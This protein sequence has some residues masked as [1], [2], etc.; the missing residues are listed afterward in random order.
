MPVKYRKISR[1]HAFQLWHQMMN[2]LTQDSYQTMGENEWKNTSEPRKPVSVRSN[3]NKGMKKNWITRSDPTGW[4]QVTSDCRD[5]STPHRMTG[6]QY[7]RTYQLQYHS[8]CSTMNPYSVSTVTKYFRQHKLKGIIY[9][10]QSNR[11]LLA[12][13]IFHNTTFKRTFQDSVIFNNDFSTKCKPFVIIWASEKC[14]NFKNAV[15]SNYYAKISDLQ[16]EP[17]G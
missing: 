4:I 11:I 8:F 17:K 5:W 12:I 15:G 2:C 10:I 13:Q 3:K 6:C 9:K 14:S 1:C 7:I 16:W